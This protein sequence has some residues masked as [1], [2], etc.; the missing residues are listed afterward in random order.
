MFKPHT[1]KQL[2]YF[3]EVIRMH[4]ELGYGED[5][6]S[7][8]LPVGHSTVNRWIA[9]F[10]KNNGNIANIMGKKGNK[11]QSSQSVEPQAMT[12]EELAE[13]IAELER[14]LRMAELRAD[15]YDEMINVAESKFNINIRK[16][17]GVKQ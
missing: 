13:R 11:E 12:K 3:D 4:Y 5:R 15:V 9:I 16:K 2:K 14:K 1:E 6:I 7:N 10:A 8:I 17:A